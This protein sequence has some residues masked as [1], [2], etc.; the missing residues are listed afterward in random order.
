MNNPPIRLAWTDFVL[1]LQD[2]LHE[3]QVKAPMYIVG[4]AVRDA[5]RRG[6]IK[7]I[8]IAVDGNAIRI[9][10]NIAD[11]FDGD[12]FVM[13]A[14]RGVARVFVTYLDEQF[15][16]DF[17]N[18][19]GETL[20]NDLQDRDFTIN[21]MAAD[22]FGDVSTLIDPMNGQDDL[23]QKILRR[24][25][26]H[27]IQDDPI[28]AIR[29][30][31]QSVELKL[32]I[33]P[34]TLEDIRDN[35]TGIEQSSFERVRDEFYKILGLDHPSRAIRV[36]QHLGILKYVIEI[37]DS[38]VGLEQSLPHRFDVW[39]HTLLVVDRMNSILKAISYRRTDN[40]AATFDLGMLVIQLDRYRAK[41]QGHI[42]QE[43][44]NGRTHQ[45]LLILG[46][47]VHNL[48]KTQSIVDHVVDTQSSAN[49]V[50]ESLR[51]SNGEQK[52][53]VT[54][55]GAYREVLDKSE[56]TTIDLHRFWFSLGESGIDAILLAVADHL[57]MVGA[58]LEQ[59][60]WLVI[61][62]RVIIMLDTYFNQYETVVDPPLYLNGNNIM[63]LLEIEG[64]PMIG[65]L[66]T[67][68]REAQ[69]TGYIT[70]VEDAH[71]F[72]KQQYSTFKID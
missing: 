14:E 39:D 71:D 26:D 19:R 61:V 40:T 11:W 3:K 66:L 33:H 20:D 49:L 45:E 5:Y 42:D 44:G 34:D 4:G 27:S 58:E 63:K 32:R 67:G 48:G 25:T 56:W 52:R 43:Y 13:D 69:V 22:F 68:L 46:A 9:A 6:A 23:N 30:I 1:D 38:L 57:G 64:S 7:D 17:A 36:L 53:L 60:E 10:R 12:V 15:V 8:D 50:A 41:L 51:L 2:I 21:A 54:M 29:G 55:V 65:Q 62:E 72:I 18:F 70:S 24:C 59:S 28:R 35:V 47:L 31:R 37:I 16:L